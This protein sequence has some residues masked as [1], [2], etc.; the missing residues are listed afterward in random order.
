MG[1]R[2][3]AT[4]LTFLIP[5]ALVWVVLVWWILAEAAG[6]HPG[7]VPIVVTIMVLGFCAVVLVGVF[8]IGQALW[9]RVR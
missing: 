4:L 3:L 8:A 2:W 9:R 5:A 7:V 1:R 6:D